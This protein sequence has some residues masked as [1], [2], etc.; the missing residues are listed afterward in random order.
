M[1]NI[2]ALSLIVRNSL[3]KLKFFKSWSKKMV[4]VTCSKLMVLLE[5]YCHKVHTCQNMKSLTLTVGRKWAFSKFFKSRSKV[6]V[7]VT[8]SISM[9]LSMVPSKIPINGKEVMGNVKI[10][11]NRSKVMV[12]VTC[13]KFMVPIERSC[14]K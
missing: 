13:S 5:R 10:F 9:V 2:K 6:T 14:N 1:P 8:C 11:K 3:A 12:N 7:K 4:K